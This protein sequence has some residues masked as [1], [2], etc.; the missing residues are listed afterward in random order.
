MKYAIYALFV[1]AHK[2]AECTEC[3]FVPQ[4]R[5]HGHPTEADMDQ[6]SASSEGVKLDSVF[7]VLR[8]FWDINCV[9]LAFLFLLVMLSD[10][11]TVFL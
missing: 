1:N 8:F 9:R 10:V 5:H 4:H 6:S 3:A 7:C 2:Y 11:L